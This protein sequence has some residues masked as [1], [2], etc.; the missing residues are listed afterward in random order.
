[1]DRIVNRISDKINGPTDELNDAITSA[2]N[3]TEATTQ[4]QATYLIGIQDTL[5]QQTEIVKSLREAIKKKGSA[6][7]PR[8]LPDSSWPPLPQPGPHLPA[9]SFS[10]ARPPHISPTVPSRLIQRVSLAA[11]QLLID[12]GPV[13]LGDPPKDRSVKAQCAL[14]GMFNEWIDNSCTAIRGGH[15][16]CPALPSSTK[17][18]NVRQPL[19]PTGV[20]LNRVQR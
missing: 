5:K 8:N 16:P 19:H 3:F 7:N 10:P 17:C 13:E 11:K 20:R 9:T 15:S 1:M 4:Q 12:Y 6:P 14:R 18:V 2:K